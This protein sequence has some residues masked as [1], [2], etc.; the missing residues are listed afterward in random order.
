MLS[1][2]WSFATIAAAAAND[3]TL[4]R[5]GRSGKPGPLWGP[6]DI[7]VMEFNPMHISGRRTEE[8]CEAASSMS[9]IGLPGTS[10]KHRKDRAL[11]GCDW[12]CVKTRLHDVYNFGFIPNKSSNKSSGAS[13]ALKRSLFPMTHIN[14]IST[15]YKIVHRSI[16]GRAGAV[17]FVNGRIDVCNIVLYFPPIRHGKFRAEYESIVKKI[18]EYFSDTLCT[19][20]TRC[21]PLVFADVNDGM[22]MQQVDKRQWIPSA[23]TSDAVG[24][25]A[26]AKEFFASTRLKG[27]AEDHKLAFVNTFFPQCK[28]TFHST[29]G[30]SR[31]DYILLPQSLLPHVSNCSTLCSLHK[32]LQ[33]IR[34]RGLRDHTPLF[35]RFFLTY[36]ASEFADCTRWDR[37]ALMQCVQG[38]DLVTRD[39][40]VSDVEQQLEQV[41][42]QS[43]WIDAT[44]HSLPDPIWHVLMSTITPIAVTHFEYAPKG[45]DPEYAYFRDERLK[46]LKTRWQLRFQM[47]CGDTS[48]LAEYFSLCRQLKEVSNMMYIVSKVQNVRNENQLV[49]ELKEAHTHN[50]VFDQHRITRRIA[51][52]GRGPKN[53]LYGLPNPRNPLV[54][55]WKE[56]LCNEPAQGGCNAQVIDFVDELADQLN[57]PAQRDLPH[58]VLDDA[59]LAQ[60]IKQ[61]ISNIQRYLIKAPKRRQVP[62]WALPLEIWWL[63]LLPNRNT[64]AVSIDQLSLDRDKVLAA[65]RK[66]TGLS[67]L[68]YSGNRN[69]V[70]A[71]TASTAIGVVRQRLFVPH[72]FSAFKQ[73]LRKVHLSLFVP[74]SWNRALA[75][76]LYKTIAKAQVHACATVRLIFLFDPISKAFF[77]S[78]IL[79]FREE[80]EPYIHS[81]HGCIAHRRRE[82]AVLTIK[83]VSWKCLRDQIGL[84]VSFMDQSNAFL[85]LSRDVAK[86]TC[87]DYIRPD[88]AL[89]AESRV[90]TACFEILCPNGT[91]CFW[92]GNGI[93]PGDPLVVQNWVRSFSPIV[94]EW[95]AKV[96]AEVPDQQV[97]HATCPLLQSELDLSHC[98]FVDDVAKLIVV[99]DNLA[100]TAVRHCQQTHSAA[101]LVF[102][103]ADLNENASKAQCLIHL[104][105]SGS[106]ANMQTLYSGVLCSQAVRDA[107]YL[108][109]RMNCNIVSNTTERDKRIQ[110]MRSGFM[111]MS[112]YWRSSVPMDRKRLIFKSNVTSH[113]TSGLTA[114]VWK[115]IDS[116]VLD[117]VTANLL[118]KAMCGTA[119]TRDVE[120]NVIKSMSNTDVLHHWRIAPHYIEL[121][122]ARL[123]MYQSWS[124]FPTSFCQPIAAMFGK[125]RCQITAEFCFSTGKAIVPYEHLNP[126]AQQL[127]QDMLALE[128]IDTG[129]EFMEEVDSRFVF[130]FDAKHPDLVQRFNA[131]DVTQLRHKCFTVCIPPPSCLGGVTVEFPQHT[132]AQQLAHVSDVEYKCMIVTDGVPCDCTQVFKHISQLHAHIRFAHQLRSI[133]RLIVRTNECCFCKSVFPSV[134]HAYR[135][136]VGACNSGTCRLD[137]SF[138]ECKLEEI[139]ELNCAVCQQAC[140]SHDA[141]QQHICQHCPSPPLR[142]E[143]T[144]RH[145]A[146]TR[147]SSAASTQEPAYIRKHRW[148][149]TSE[150]WKYWKQRLQAEGQGQQEGSQVRQGTTDGVAGV[151]QRGEHL[152]EGH[153][154]GEEG[155]AR[156]A[157]SHRP[158]D[159]GVRSG[160]RHGK[161]GRGGAQAVLHRSEEREAGGQGR[162]ASSSGLRH[163]GSSDSGRHHAV[164]DQA[165]EQQPHWGGQ[166]HLRKAPKGRGRVSRGSGGRQHLAD[167]PGGRHAVSK[168]VRRQEETSLQNPARWVGK[169]KSSGASAT[170]FHVGQWRQHQERQAADVG[171]GASDPGPA[172]PDRRGHGL[173]LT[174]KAKSQSAE[175]GDLS[176]TEE[177]IPWLDQSVTWA[178]MSMIVDPSFLLESSDG[179]HRP[180][181]SS[182]HDAILPRQECLNGVN[183]SGCAQ[184]HIDT[185]ASSSHPASSSSTI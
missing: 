125:L 134:G 24:N 48:N 116:Q 70:P 39:N 107:R 144:A 25:V 133:L 65:L 136:L 74:M 120:G 129:L 6:R 164:R 166:G 105:G 56:Y 118:R 75:A 47:I 117:K 84:L 151:V 142:L 62:P 114:F 1:R 68:S 162:R 112:K 158:E 23:Q 172:G 101:K 51:A 165:H 143:F 79:D 138:Y 173:A 2:L 115:E 181:E 182:T 85:S 16:I 113:A 41:M 81:A 104:S 161:S 21:T 171:S 168:S 50:K 17:R 92:P 123:L 19:L 38:K 163:S 69:I 33:P 54:D 90:T 27:V 96:N 149:I 76:K 29:F 146:K 97:L 98:E 37:D 99:P 93:L 42:Q 111:Q 12:T 8:I 106:H 185:E 89:L 88:D 180:F 183:R 110:S 91:I 154:G 64:V 66:F 121:Q 63:L 43:D 5:R 31:P 156:A 126:W 73:V 80:A 40:F 169:G 145:V 44:K 150:R 71:A 13:V 22:G 148:R 135:H 14:S 160:L 102:G 170:L 7:S 109:S 100:S 77:S 132:I 137:A 95:I 11:E 72:I 179:P 59:N 36:V 28:P 86:K 127:F 15:P 175:A 49:D 57:D 87:W 9:V 55:Q 60:K 52:N 53:R 167:S 34:S 46:L 152:H 83:I 140:L 103:K 58:K 61:E 174:R 26:P 67:W 108:G 119:V 3:A 130:L 141:Y 20:P 159:H 176:N 147:S 178:G 153:H 128:Q 10:C 82:S 45:A 139:T 157:G 18:V 4:Y 177:H 78:L 131:I 35:A 32:K 124:M 94:T 155:C 122:V 30:S 184:P